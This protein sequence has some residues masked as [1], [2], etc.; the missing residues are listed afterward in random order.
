MNIMNI[1]NTYKFVL[2]YCPALPF[3]VDILP[4]TKAVIRVVEREQGVHGTFL[5]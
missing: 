1:I 4:L 3:D 5:Q 2:N